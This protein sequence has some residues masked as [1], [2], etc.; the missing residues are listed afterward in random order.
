MELPSETTRKLQRIQNSVAWRV[1][2][3][4]QIFTNQTVLILCLPP[5]CVGSKQPRWNFW[6]WESLLL[7]ASLIQREGILLL[8]NGRPIFMNTFHKKDTDVLDGLKHVWSSACSFFHYWGTK[9]DKRYTRAALVV[10]IRGPFTPASCIVQ[11][12]TSGI[13]KSHMLGVKA[14]VLPH[15]P[16][17]VPTS[18]HLRNAG[19]QPVS[20]L[21]PPLP[22]PLLNYLS[23]NSWLL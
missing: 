5:S 20:R 22:P 6:S 4:A 2:A 18:K 1:E 13:Q 15:F 14:I 10:Q 7:L 8:R 16:T 3:G 11:W 21:H 9:C 23:F 17:P 12:P 19:L